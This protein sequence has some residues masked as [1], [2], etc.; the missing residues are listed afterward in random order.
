MNSDREL[1]AAIVGYGGMAQNHA[2]LMQRH[3]IRPA[4][5][6]DT[7]PQRL[8]AAAAEYPGIMT[9]GTLEAMLARPDLDLAVIVT[10]H[11]LHAPLAMSVIRAGKHCIIEKP[12]C[13]G[14]KEGQ[15]LI[16]AASDNK[17]MLSVYHNRRWD[18]WFLKL[19][20]LMAQ[21]VLG[22]IFYVE[23]LHSGYQ[24]PGGAPRMQWRADKRSSGGILYDWGAHY[25]DWLLGI[26]PAGVETVRGYAQKRVF[27]GITNEDQ[28][29]GIIRFS[30]GAVAHLQISSISLV[31]RHRIQIL[32]TKGAVTEQGNGTLILNTR[33]N[34]TPVETMLPYEKGSGSHHLFYANIR[35][36]LLYGAE[37]A[38]KPEQALTTVAVLE[39]ITRSAEDGREHAFE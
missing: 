39:A 3:G 18:G 16:R 4:A 1:R 35:E 6:Y 31:K 36:H 11:Y 17:V 5:V 2:R 30:D 7:N 21:E 22:D 23:M 12:M 9:F 15:E 8:E 37:L 32:G 33:E 10:P 19:R 28:V 34:G 24:E 38:V 26:M 14:A 13:I 27:T 29:D 20:E 25:I